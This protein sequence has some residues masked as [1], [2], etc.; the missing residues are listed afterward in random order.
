MTIVRSDWFIA[1]IIMFV[2]YLLIGYCVASVVRRW[3]EKRFVLDPLKIVA[4]S[5]RKASWSSFQ[6]LYFTFIVLWLSIFWLLKYDQ[7]VP[8]Q[9]D[10]WILLGIAGAGT[11]LGKS[12]DNSRSLLSQVNFSWI[13][14]KKWIM[15]D[16][17]RGKYETRTPRLF[18]LITTDGQFDISRF[19]AVGFTVIIGVALFLEGIGLDADSAGAF[20]FSI[21]QTYLALIGVSQGVYI[22]GKVSQKDDLKQLDRKLD[23]VREKEQAFGM[24]VSDHADWK[25]TSGTLAG[26]DSRPLFDLACK[27]A[28]T[29]YSDFLYVSKEA[30]NL[31]RGLTGKAIPESAMRPLLPPVYS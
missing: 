22:G 6:V 27:C 15:R 21:G 25:A 20:T 16:L 13:R 19:Q 8:L 23:Q 18:D 10:L 4:G 14:D 17:I 9:G 2:V 30:A 12:T 29:E 31:V 11:V 3:T 5:N 1:T 24:A 7:L 26:G 28:P